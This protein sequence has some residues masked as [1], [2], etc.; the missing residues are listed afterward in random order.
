MFLDIWSRC[1]SYIESFVQ[2][3]PDDDSRVYP[4]SAQVDGTSNRWVFNRF[5]RVRGKTRKTPVSDK[6]TDN[7]RRTVVTPARGAN[8][9]LVGG[10]THVDDDDTVDRRYVMTTS[11]RTCGYST[12]SSTTTTTTKTVQLHHSDAYTG[13]NVVRSA[14]RTGRRVG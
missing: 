8:R 2:S 6:R 12:R 10:T 3:V 4:T 1:V 13:Q 11:V 9:N 14:E 5:R 7:H